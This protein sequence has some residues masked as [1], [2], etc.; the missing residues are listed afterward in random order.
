MQKL[1]KLNLVYIRKVCILLNVLRFTEKKNA[2]T[3]T[4]DLC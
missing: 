3:R 1:T 4:S 2:F